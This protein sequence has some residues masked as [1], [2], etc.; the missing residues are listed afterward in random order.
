MNELY[1]EHFLRRA[2]EEWYDSYVDNFGEDKDMIETRLIE[3]IDH[4]TD[5]KVELCR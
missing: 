1:E 5:G 3:I 4:A 2:I